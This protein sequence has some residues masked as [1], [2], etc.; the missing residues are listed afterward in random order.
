MTRRHDATARV[1]NTDAAARGPGPRGTR[2][3]AAQDERRASPHPDHPGPLQIDS[4]H[5]RVRPRSPPRADPDAREREATG[6]DPLRDAVPGDDRTVAVVLVAVEDGDYAGV[7]GEDAS[8]SSAF[9]RL[10]VKGP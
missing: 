4:E 3:A 1:T 2:A 10:R 8:S 9:S 5:P 6:H 7:P